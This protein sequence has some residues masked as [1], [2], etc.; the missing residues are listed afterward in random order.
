MV[1]PYQNGWGI[2]MN[3]KPN[4]IQ[5]KLLASLVV[6]IPILIGTHINGEKIWKVNTYES[7]VEAA[8]ACYDWRIESKGR[9]CIPEWETNSFLGMS[10]DKVIKVYRY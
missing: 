3:V 1:K 9:E 6:I 7:R 5:D 2:D 4:S 10:D 8:Q